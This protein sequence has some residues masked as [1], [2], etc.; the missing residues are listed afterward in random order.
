MDYQMFYAS[1]EKIL[2]SSNALYAMI[3]FAIWTQTVSTPF[4]SLHTDGKTQSFIC[5]PLW[6][7]GVEG[8]DVDNA[9][10]GGIFIGISDDG[11]LQEKGFT[12]FKDE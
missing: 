8:K 2:L 4:A 6:G 7:V 12:E 11:I 5:Q 3:L 10:V 9:H 1:L